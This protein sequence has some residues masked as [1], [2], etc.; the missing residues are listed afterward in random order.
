MGVTYNIEEKKFVFDFE[1]DGAEEED[2]QNNDDLTNFIKKAVD[3]LSYQ[4]NSYDYNLVV[5]RRCLT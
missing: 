1:H 4:I 2:L 3:N 5:I